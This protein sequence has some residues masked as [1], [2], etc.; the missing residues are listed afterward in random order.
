MWVS[1]VHLGAR[2]CQAARLAE[3]LAQI[4][5]PQ[6]Y[7]VGDTLDAWKLRRRW[8]WPQSHHAVVKRIVQMAEAGTEVT[9]LP[10]NH[11]E[12][13]RNYL[14]LRLGNIK[15]VDDCVHVLLDARRLLVIHGDQFD[16]VIIH[17]KWLAFVGER[18]YTLAIYINRIFNF[19]RRKLGFTY[20]SL[21]AYLKQ[22]VKAAAL[23]DYRDHLIRAARDRKMDGVICGHTHT[24]EMIEK[25]GILYVND[26]DWV[27]SCSALV[28][29]LD[30][31][32]EMID[33]R[34]QDQV[35]T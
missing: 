27:E 7:L 32:L 3:F 35:N 26:G 13:L 22:R 33:F 5:T 17:A 2:E 9:L 16:G 10:G 28:E 25:D 6:L 20:W 34:P 29:H 1:D 4:E 23:H 8:Y 19:V 15:I 12:M 30:G 11:D 31:R 24:P 14:G 18:A 21:S